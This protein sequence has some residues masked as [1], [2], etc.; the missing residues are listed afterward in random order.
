MVPVDFYDFQLLI[1][2]MHG[3]ILI[4]FISSGRQRRNF[5]QEKN[6][7]F[8]CSKFFSSSLLHIRSSIECVRDKRE[9]ERD[10][11]LIFERQC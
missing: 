5:N 11:V 7:R 9:R 3:E 4:R 8:L 1:H 6:R 10:S 2:R